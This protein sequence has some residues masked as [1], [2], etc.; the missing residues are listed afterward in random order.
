MGMAFTW[1]YAAL[2]SLMGI[3]PHEVRQA[4]Q[5]SWPRLGH[6]PDLSLTAVTF[7]GR[8]DT[9]RALLVATRRVG[10][11]DWEIVG[12]RDLTPAELAE[13]EQWEADRNG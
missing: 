12:A 5:G 7:W 8:T 4:L 2:A 10:A 9:G 13:L 3:E 1:S 11:R 6:S